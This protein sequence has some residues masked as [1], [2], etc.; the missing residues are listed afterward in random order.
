MT[1]R[2][3]IFLSTRL[4]VWAFALPALAYD[5]KYRAPPNYAQLAARKILAT[6]GESRKVLSAHIT[7]P[8]ERFMGI[9]ND[10]MRPIICVRAEYE[11]PIISTGASYLAMFENGQISQIIRTRLRSIVSDWRSGR[12]KSS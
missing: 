2:A 4:A 5:A 6:Y 10:G 3:S 7:E 8:G 9:M 11:A 1:K 12:S